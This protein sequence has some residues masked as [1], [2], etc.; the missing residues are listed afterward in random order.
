MAKCESRGSRESSS[1]KDNRKLASEK[2]SRMGSVGR[3]ARKN[4]VIFLS[5]HQSG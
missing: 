1:V 4:R 3:G 5:N 2:E